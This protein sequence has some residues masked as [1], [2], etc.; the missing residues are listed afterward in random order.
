MILAR[1]AANRRYSPFNYVES[2]E[3]HPSKKKNWGKKHHKS[4]MWN[5]GAEMGLPK[6]AG[7]LKGMD[8]ADPIPAPYG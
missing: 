1:Y 4:N 5:K 8:P 6:E 2:N 3:A 7:I